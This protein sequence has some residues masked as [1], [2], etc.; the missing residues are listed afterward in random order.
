MGYRGPGEVQIVGSDV[1]PECQ[2]RRG[3][4]RYYPGRKFPTVQTPQTI[5]LILHTVITGQGKILGE[6]VAETGE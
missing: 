3:R 5:S 2:L 4:L 6:G 1:L